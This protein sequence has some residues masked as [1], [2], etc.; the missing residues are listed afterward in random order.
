MRAKP[1]VE[2]VRLL[3]KNDRSQWTDEAFAAAKYALGERGLHDKLEAV[4]KVQ[5]EWESA[6]RSQQNE[7]KAKSL[8]QLARL[9]ADLKRRRALAPMRRFFKFFLILLIL[10]AG[11]YL[12]QSSRPNSYQDGNP[13]MA[14]L[15][16]ILLA[17]GG[18]MGLLYARSRLKRTVFWERYLKQSESAE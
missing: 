5:S 16:L 12:L 15:G 9:E 4:S 1:T 8:A 17:A 11:E 2:L 6:N 18:T 13:T 3:I 10:L 7:A 14:L